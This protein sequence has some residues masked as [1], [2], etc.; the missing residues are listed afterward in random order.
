MIVFF[1][2]IHFT[3]SIE[4]I[5]PQSSIFFQINNVSLPRLLR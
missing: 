4:T 3:F 1:S 2:I 5:D